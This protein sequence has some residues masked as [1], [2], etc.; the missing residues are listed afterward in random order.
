MNEIKI[1]TELCAED[2]ARL[3]KIAGLL[4]ANIEASLRIPTELVALSTEETAETPQET[5]KA[6]DQ[7]NTQPKA[8]TQ[9]QPQ[10]AEPESVETEEQKPEKVDVGVEDIRR[11]VVTLSA[12]GKKDE[13]RKVVQTYA[14]TVSD[15]PADKYVEVWTELKALEV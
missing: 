15:L 2:R 6:E 10:K 5:T 7:G 11:L 1:I 4:E 9:A 3:D 8:E 14:R 12:S 13:A